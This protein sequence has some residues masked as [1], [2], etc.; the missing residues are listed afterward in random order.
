MALKQS[1]YVDGFRIP[2]V[3]NFQAGVVN[4]QRFEY[5]IA[6]NLSIGDIIEMCYLPAGCTLVDFHLDH[7]AL[8]VS[9]TA[10]VGFMSGTV[11]E[12]DAG[13]TSGDELYG[14][15][16]VAA[17]GFKRATL[18]TALRQAGNVNDR[19]IGFKIGGAGVTAASQKVALTLFYVQ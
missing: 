11:G 17:A 12:D 10:D 16:D 1:K 8:G 9:V 14:G 3:Q 4:A 6:A 18:V 19:S 2:T 15:A 5:V 7:D 13:R